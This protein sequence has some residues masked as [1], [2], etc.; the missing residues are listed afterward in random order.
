MTRNESLRAL[1]GASTVAATLL[2]TIWLFHLADNTLVPV[3]EIANDYQQFTVPA[4]RESLVACQKKALTQGGLT[5]NQDKTC[6][7]TARTI[8]HT[9]ARTQ[10]LY[11]VWAQVLSQNK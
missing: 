11:Q 10:T 3:N 1:L 2:F 6:V 5:Y 4:A 9:T 8:E 7:Q